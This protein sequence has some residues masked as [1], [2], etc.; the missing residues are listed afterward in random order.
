MTRTIRLASILSFLLL[1]IAGHAHALCVS[2][3]QA[4]LRQGPGTHYAKTWEVYQYMPL[5]KIGQRGKW[6]HVRD[7]DGDRHWVHKR[8][9]SKKLHCAVV[10]GARANV[11]TGPGTRYRQ[12]AWSPIDAYYSFRIIDRSG[13]WVKVRDEVGNTGWI[14]RSLLWEQ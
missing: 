8:L 6:L 2:S 1:G 14:T 12:A 5:K 7:L 3:P 10:K 13:R 9:I 4:N 11:R